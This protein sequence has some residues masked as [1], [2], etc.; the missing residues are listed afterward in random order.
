MEDKRF[1]VVTSVTEMI[2]IPKE[3]HDQLV[4]DSKFLEA[5]RATGVDNWEGFE[6]A[7]ELLEQD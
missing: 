6:V 4:D 1:R 5:L 2:S 3:E 7:R